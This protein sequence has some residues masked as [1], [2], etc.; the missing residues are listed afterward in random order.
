MRV[1]LFCVSAE[2]QPIRLCASLFITVGDLLTGTGVKGGRKQREKEKKKRGYIRG[3]LEFCST[4]FFSLVVSSSAKV[5]FSSFFSAPPPFRLSVP[6]LSSVKLKKE[7]GKSGKGQRDTHS[8]AHPP[9]RSKRY[10]QT[11]A[12]KQVE[13]KAHTDHRIKEKKRQTHT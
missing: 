1:L 4:E 12:I 6:R 5:Q 8:H 9:R 11:P 10:T 13:R 3:L 2:Y 7:K